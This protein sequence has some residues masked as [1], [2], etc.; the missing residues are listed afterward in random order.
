[1]PVT[2]V[3]RERLAWPSSAGVAHHSHQGALIRQRGKSGE[4][5]LFPIQ[6]HNGRLWPHDSRLSCAQSVLTPNRKGWYG[7]NKSNSAACL[8]DECGKGNNSTN[9]LLF[10]SNLCFVTRPACVGFGTSRCARSC[11]GAQ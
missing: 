5:L 3:E 7:S 9:K 4:T 10:P 8:K 6:L 11:V 2:L 1:M